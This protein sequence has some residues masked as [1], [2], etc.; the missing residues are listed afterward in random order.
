MNVP[1]AALLRT[2]LLWLLLLVCSVGMG[3]DVKLRFHVVDSKTK[4]P[5]TFFRY[6]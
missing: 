2:P 1:R 3:K 4:K 6:N 5:V